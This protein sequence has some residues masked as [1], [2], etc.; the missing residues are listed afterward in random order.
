MSLRIGSATP[1]NLYVGGAQA[2]RSYLGS[3]LV[4]GDA[5][6]GGG[7]GPAAFVSV[8][9]VLGGSTVDTETVA[10]PAAG[11][12]DLLIVIT[13]N[14][15]DDVDN[16][17]QTPSAGWTSAG[18]FYDAGYIG[19]GPSIVWA[20]GTVTSL[21]FTRPAAGGRR[22][23]VVM[24]VSGADLVSPIADSAFSL[25]TENWGDT[26]ILAP[27]VTTTGGGLAIAAW[28]NQ[29]SSLTAGSAP[30]NYTNRLNR[31]HDVDGPSVLIATRDNTPAGVT[32][33]LSH[34]IT[35]G[36]WQSRTMLQIAVRSA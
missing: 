16:T 34:G 11:A 5:P 27:S 28:I 7:G 1:P 17:P 18:G 6:G 25:V 35:S 19:L 23:H 2:L 4:F 29:Q 30:A 32:G 12:T 9:S 21:T 20:P 3:T 33:T 26:N 8:T 14:D 15:R 10:L 36:A 24:V 22:Q 31:P 13:L